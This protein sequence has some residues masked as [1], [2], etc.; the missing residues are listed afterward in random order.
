MSPTG[1]E[2]GYR[3]GK[4]NLQLGLWAQSFGGFVFD[5]STLFQLPN[6]AKRSPDAAWISEKRWLSLTL[7]ERKGFPPIAPDFVIELRSESDRLVD[8]QAKMQ[9]YVDN[10]VRLGWLI[11]PFERQVHAY[12]PSKLPETVTSDSISNQNYLP[13][14]VLNLRP[15]WAQE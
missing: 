3:N 8:L 9:E 11:D 13:G 15:I 5:S 10:G 6:G 7:E 2:T 14:F 12:E 4:I 1:G